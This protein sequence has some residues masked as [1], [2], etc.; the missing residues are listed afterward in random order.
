MEIKRINTFY[1]SPTG[2]TKKVCEQLAKSL[3]DEVVSYDRTDFDKRW[4]RVVFTEEDMVII[5]V[6]CYFG[7]MPQIVKEFFRYVCATNTLAVLVTT[8]G[9]RDYE[10]TLLEMKEE[11]ETRGFRCIAAGAFVGEHSLNAQM[12]TQRPDLKDMK[13]IEAFG[14]AI[15]Q[16]VGKLEDDQE[17]V[18][19]VR[20]EKPYTHQ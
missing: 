1:L 12:G 8:Y 5:G 9:N 17:I 10:D 3:S 11:A 2:N 20:G 19:E 16:L 13:E 15:I 7:R 14:E 18:L 4:E 6:P